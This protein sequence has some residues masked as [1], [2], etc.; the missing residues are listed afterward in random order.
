M[1]IQ[2]GD[3]RVGASDHAVARALERV[4]AL[5]GA[6]PTAAEYWVEET[7]ARALR[8]G[9][10]A[11]RAPRWIAR[12][13]EEGLRRRGSAYPDR[14]SLF[15]WDPGETTSLLV[16][17]QGGVWTVVTVVTVSSTERSAEV[18]GW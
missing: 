2:L 12:E 9:R 1:T 5:A 13:W 7:A 10:K 4:P 3:I 8:D 11:K 16:T 14:M 15:V 18:A 6:S 17:K